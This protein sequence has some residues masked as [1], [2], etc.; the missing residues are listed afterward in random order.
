[1]GRLDNDVGINIVTHRRGSSDYRYGHVIIQ[2]DRLARVAYE[3][4]DGSALRGKMLKVRQF[5]Q[6]S[7]NNDRRASNWQNQA[8]NNTERRRTDRRK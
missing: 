3:S 8:W 1:M 2:S 4:I 7:G 5:I 6:R